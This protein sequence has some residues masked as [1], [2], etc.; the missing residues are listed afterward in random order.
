MR[1]ICPNCGAQYEVADDVIPDTGRDVQCSNCGH[2]WLEQPGASLAAESEDFADDQDLQDDWDDA[3]PQ[4]S[5]PTEAFDPPENDDDRMS[6]APRPPAP[7]QAEPQRRGL[8]P[9]IADILREEA[10]REESARAAER[11]AGLE[12]QGDLGLVEGSDPSEQREQEARER[13]SRLKGDIPDVEDVVAATVAGSRKELLPDIEEINS[14]LRPSADRAEA[15][16]LPEELEEEQRRGFRFGFL[17]VLGLIILLSLVYLFAD[18]IADAVPA[19]SGILESYVNAVN[20]LRIWLDVQIAGLLAALESSDT[21][22][23]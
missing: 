8:D 9:S 11:E 10:A 6:A 16:P 13:I 19:L 2:T 15:Q 22:E 5:R 20:S 14:T 23:G 18:A 21:P 17:S 12:S 1:L 4:V 7:D 3:D